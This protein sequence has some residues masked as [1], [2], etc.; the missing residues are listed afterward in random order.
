MSR[1]IQPV[2]SSSLPFPMPVEAQSLPSLSKTEV[3]TVTWKPAVTTKH[4]H[5]SL[6]YA[7]LPCPRWMPLPTCRSSRIPDSRRSTCPAS[8]PG[9]A[10][11]SHCVLLQ[12]VVTQAW[13]PTRQSPTRPLKQRAAWHSPPWPTS[14]APRRLPLPWRM[15]VLTTAWQLRMT[16]PA[17]TVRSMS[18]STR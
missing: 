15:A 2:P 13:S 5:N 18:L 3:W 11:A 7:L 8:R 10:K 16:T 17:S 1:P 9:L 14:L 6:K 12:Q 4:L